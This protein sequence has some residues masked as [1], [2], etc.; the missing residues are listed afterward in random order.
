MGGQP[1]ARRTTQ[2]HSLFVAATLLCSLILWP[3][4][5]AFAQTLV[6]IIGTEYY[7]LYFPDD[8]VNLG[9]LSGSDIHSIDFDDAIE[10]QRKRVIRT[11]NRIKALNK[12]LNDKDLNKK[13]LK[14]LKGT[15][16]NLFSPQGGA[17]INEIRQEKLRKAIRRERQKLKLYQSQLDKIFDCQEKKPVASEGNVTL[18]FFSENVID[19]NSQK[20]MIFSG[21]Y[22]EAP[23]PQKSKRNNTYSLGHTA[24]NTRQ[25]TLHLTR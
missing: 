16:K 4:P 11:K 18:K 14:L 22:I 20:A 24:P 17:S 5:G 7:C 3:T 19:P 13:D 23:Y 9:Q 15:L 21:Y 2:L 10:T 8:S 25:Q 12:L 1:T 6:P